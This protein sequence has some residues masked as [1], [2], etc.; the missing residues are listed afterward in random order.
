MVN[1]PLSTLYPMVLSMLTYISP[2]LKTDGNGY[3]T[4]FE[5]NEEPLPK[6]LTLDTYLD[7]ISYLDT[8]NFTLYTRENPTDGEILKLNDVES[9]RNSHWNATKQT[10]IVTHGW[11]HSGEAPVCTTIRDGFL[12]VRDCNVIILDW[13]EIAD[14]L[15]YS[16]V[17]EI[18]P[19]VAQRTASFINFMRTEAGLRTSNLKI[20]GHSFGAQIAGLSAREVGKSSRVAEVIALDPSNVMFQHK[21]PGER[22]DKSDAENVQII[23]TC[24]GGHGYYLSV[25]T[26]DFYANDGRHQP[27]CGIDLFGICA[28]LRSYKFFAE[29]I[30]NP[31]GFLGTR[32][33]GATA[34]MGGATPDPKAKGTYYFKTT[35]Q[36]PFALGG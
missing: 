30:T 15:I 11:T 16:V 14:K 28:H 18:V 26:S 19:H 2:T 23:H 9:I 5:I 24:A 17:A 6:N 12:K 35:G 34:Y 27:G 10:I 13:S 29:S 21:K 25:G 7:A 20:V 1:V 8:I 3:I 33:D 36:Y 31:K 22:L 32:A 4:R